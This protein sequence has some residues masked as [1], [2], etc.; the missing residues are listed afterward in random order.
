MSLKEEHVKVGEETGERRIGDEL[1]E[2]LR[3]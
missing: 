3:D 2:R 1:K